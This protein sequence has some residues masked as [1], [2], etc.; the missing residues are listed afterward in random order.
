MTFNG[1]LVVS[2]S[3]LIGVAVIPAQ[4]AKLVDAFMES[5]NQPSMSLLS[6]PTSRR[7]RQQKKKKKKKA[8]KSTGYATDGMGPTG[9]SIDVPP[10]EIKTTKTPS[11]SSTIICD[12][13]GATGK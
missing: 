1:R 8:T 2:G 6:S 5:Q 3:I 12:R 4:A 9:K 10:E 7:R 11:T 13:C